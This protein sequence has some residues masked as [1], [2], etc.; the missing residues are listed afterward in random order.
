MD[1]LRK[2]AA[3]AVEVMEREMRGFL[4]NK[5]IL[6]IQGFLIIIIIIHIIIMK[7]NESQFALFAASP[8]LID[9]EG[10]L[11]K[12]GAEFSRVDNATNS[13][14]Q[15]V[16]GQYKK[17]YFVLKGNLLFYFH[18][19]S[20]AAPIGV[21]LVEG[22]RVQHARVHDR[23]E[24]SLVPI[25]EPN[26]RIFHFLAESDADGHAWVRAFEHASLDR[27]KTSL[28][29]LWTRYQQT[30]ALLQECLLALPQRRAKAS[31]IA[32]ASTIARVSSPLS[33]S[34]SAAAA[35]ASSSSSSSLDQS[36]MS[37][38]IMRMGSDNT[39]EV[40]LKGF[41]DKMRNL[42]ESTPTSPPLSAMKNP[43][44]ISDDRSSL[45]KPLMSPALPVPEP[46]VHRS[47]SSSRPVSLLTA[48]LRPDSALS[49]NSIH[50]N[51]DKNDSPTGLFRPS[52]TSPTLLS[53]FLTRP[54]MLCFTCTL[55]EPVVHAI[56]DLYVGIKSKRQSW[57]SRWIAGGEPVENEVLLV[58]F[59]RMP[60]VER[61]DDWCWVE[62]GRTEISDIKD[63]RHVEFMVPVWL[64]SL[65]E[66]RDAEF[67][68]ELQ[69]FATSKDATQTRT[70]A[71]VEC[72]R[73]QLLTGV[74]SNTSSGRPV[75]F[76]SSGTD[77]VVTAS[78]FAPSNL[79]DVLSGI[80]HVNG[81]DIVGELVVTLSTPPSF[82]RAFD[83]SPF[84]NRLTLVISQVY[85]VPS[86]RH[87][88]LFVRER[89][90]ESPFPQ[91]TAFIL[92]RHFCRLEQTILNALSDKR[93]MEIYQDRGSSEED[94]AHAKHLQK[95]NHIL[96]VHR[97]L[98]G[99][100]EEVMH[101]IAGRA[102]TA[103]RCRAGWLR[104]STDKKDL[105][106]QWMTLN[107]N[108]HELWQ[109]QKTESDPIVS[110]NQ[111]VTCG[112]FAAHALGFSDKAS[113]SAPAYLP[114][115]LLCFTGS[116]DG[117]LLFQK[118]VG[119]LFDRLDREHALSGFLMD[120]ARTCRGLQA[121]N[122]DSGV[123]EALRT[124]AEFVLESAS[125]AT[126]VL[127]PLGE[128]VSA[129]EEFIKKKSAITWT[130]DTLLSK[131]IPLVTDSLKQLL[132]GTVDEAK[133]GQSLSAASHHFGRF[134][135]KLST[136]LHEEAVSADF[137]ALEVS[138]N[139]PSSLF[140]FGFGAKNNTLAGSL[141]ARKR[142]DA[143]FSQA[144]GALLT[145]FW[146]LISRHFRMRR[147]SD[148]KPA[149]SPFGSLGRRRS[150]ELFNPISA[151]ALQKAE[152]A[153]FWEALIHC[154]YLCQFESLLSTQGDESGM[155]ED[156]ITAVMR[157][158]K[159]RLTV[160]PCDNF[161]FMFDGS[162]DLFDLASDGAEPIQ[163]SGSRENLTVSLGIPS[164]IFQTVPFSLARG[165]AFIQPHVL[166]FTQGI[167]EQ[168]VLA[169]L[170]GDTSIQ[171]KVN[172]ES[173]VSLDSY[174]KKWREWIDKLIDRGMISTV[175]GVTIRATYPEELFDLVDSL[176]TE[177]RV[178]VGLDNALRRTASVPIR[179]DIRKLSE[180]EYLSRT[181]STNSLRGTDSPRI[182]SS[183]AAPVP[184]EMLGSSPSFVPD[185][186]PKPKKNYFKNQTNTLLLAAEITR[187]LSQ[188][189]VSSPL[190][191]TDAYSFP[192]DVQSIIYGE[193]S[194]HAGGASASFVFYPTPP[195]ASRFTS[196]KSAKDR[197]SLSVTLE[198]AL[199]LRSNKR[200]G[201]K[202]VAIEAGLIVESS[203]GRTR[204]MAASRTE[205]FTAVS[206]DRG[207][208]LPR[209]M[210]NIHTDY[211]TRF[212]QILRSE[213]GARLA[214]VERNLGLGWGSLVDRDFAASSGYHLSDI[215]PSIDIAD[216]LSPIR[217]NNKEK[218]YF[219]FH[220]EPPLAVIPHYFFDGQ[221][222]D[223]EKKRRVRAFRGGE[224]KFAFNQLQWTMLPPAYRPPLRCTNGGMHN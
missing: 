52:S 25:S 119:E 148:V 12:R 115:N 202:S 149:L 201:L 135:R 100:Y 73:R 78:L 223:E 38:E 75:S 64:N 195:L 129:N 208:K 193:S 33:Q 34:V 130:K 93:I 153:L 142:Q 127:A 86:S 112:A 7:T 136:L 41:V 65:A 69:C 185:S 161:E 98:F 40:V 21:V 106:T 156:M 22:Y 126:E 146:G 57:T 140:S 16:L 175:S 23:F 215:H 48:S 66:N 170:G 13:S 177:L 110:L 46:L 35:V 85:S 162:N 70:V 196:C 209:F 81:G 122:K 174:L 53:D 92:S 179:N 88:H 4:A 27:L 192:E 51:D 125:F 71:F 220:E 14:R 214:N 198:S 166:I 121:E 58:A 84:S 45:P 96:D 49:H 59:E 62:R 8:G 124:W 157:I 6:K 101:S 197:T 221:L 138:S 2:A 155:L 169:N 168:Q 180:T 83:P 165:Q 114:P 183:Y 139:Q 200:S 50:H 211:F 132:D 10:W 68:F 39:D 5:I 56:S 80:K 184:L 54:V 24:L 187:L 61:S 97:E 158:G 123:W 105:D 194:E 17:R 151:A 118:Q 152:D 181:M 117:R 212:V 203:V 108:M 133:F 103:K 134:I 113:S 26:G 176:M 178:S 42:F 116:L 91:W 171:E 204:S 144:L 224:G 76:Y 213:Q 131:M 72:N 150:S 1:Q 159:I 90:A 145:G 154:G 29:R 182:S 207:Q 63:S 30:H 128:R 15:S 19:K 217:E 31:T 3:A 164:I 28:T 43:P 206:L 111:T 218:D 210:E 167:N 44:D 32:A 77:K 79:R 137:E 47:S 9:Q 191:Y 74:A 219:S 188:C 199:I 143:C 222:V 60:L 36:I 37:A 104:K 160:H 87:H 120:L 55:E 172:V 173:V 18:F 94:T 67:R 186:A 82:P 163:I 141:M 109:M 190:G 205:S 107:C 11:W 89:L 20:S 216:P 95:L 189:N 147:T 102:D 99:H